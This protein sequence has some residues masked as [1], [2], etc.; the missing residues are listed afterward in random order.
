MLCCGTGVAEVELQQ[1]S[2]LA[3]AYFR[4]TT[5][6]RRCHTNRNGSESGA[7]LRLVLETASFRPVKFICSVDMLRVQTR[8]AEKWRNPRSFHAV[9]SNRENT[10]W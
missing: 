10:R 7:L 1:L 9:F 4:T 2:H 3:T 8:K 5:F 6:T